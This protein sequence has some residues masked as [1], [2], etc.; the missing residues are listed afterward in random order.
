M[1]TA[2]CAIPASGTTEFWIICTC[3]T[4][5]QH[6]GTLW[7]QHFQMHFTWIGTGTRVVKKSELKTWARIFFLSAAAVFLGNIY[8]VFFYFIKRQ[9]P[10][11]STKT[12]LKGQAGIV[13]MLTCP[14][15]VAVFV[16]P[17]LT[18]SLQLKQN[19]FWCSAGSACVWQ[20]FQ[21]LVLLCTGTKIPLP[22]KI[23]ETHLSLSEVGRV[24]S[25]CRGL[26]QFITLRACTS[27]SICKNKPAKNQNNQA[28]HGVQG[29]QKAGKQRTHGIVPS[30]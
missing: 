15:P 14:S 13:S 20:T 23:Q 11:D 16:W 2:S 27:S 4:A 5:C 10:R 7:E 8:W 25:T 18:K 19:L 9:Q 1:S 28:L 3:A 6:T 21:D 30:P 26:E 29:A 17:S 12:K 22:P 24:G